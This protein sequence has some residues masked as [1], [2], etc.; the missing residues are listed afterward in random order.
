MHIFSYADYVGKNKTQSISLNFVK[1]AWGSN[2]HIRKQ[3]ILFSIHDVIKKKKSVSKV[4]PKSVNIKEII[5]QDPKVAYD[6][7][8]FKFKNIEK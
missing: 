7:H 5:F 6:I 1:H 3:S 4:E 2:G 8:L